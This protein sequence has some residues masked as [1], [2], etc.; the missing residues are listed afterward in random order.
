MN[1]I[2]LSCLIFACFFPFISPFGGN[3]DLDSLT[4]S[5]GMTPITLSGD[6]QQFGSSVV[7]CDFNGDGTKDIIFGAAGANGFAGAVYVL[8]GGASFTA[9]DLNPFTPSATKGLMITTSATYM[10]FGNI[11]ACVGDLNGDLREELVIGDGTGLYFYLVRPPATFIGNIELTSYADKSTFFSSTGNSEI[12]NVAALGDVNGDTRPDFILSIKNTAAGGEHFAVVYL[13]GYSNLNLDLDAPNPANAFKVTY[14]GQIGGLLS[15]A[16]AG[17]FND[18]TFADFAI[19][20][21]YTGD[22]AAVIFGGSGLGNIDLASGAFTLSKGVFIIGNAAFG[23]GKSIAYAGDVNGDKFSDIIIGASG[24]DSGNGAAFIIKGA[25]SFT[26]NIDVTTSPISGGS[27]GVIIKHSTVTGRGLGTSVFGGIKSDL[28]G[29][30]GTVIVCDALSSS[31]RCYFLFRALSGRAS[32]TDVDT[33]LTADGFAIRASTSSNQNALKFTNL[34]DINSDGSPDFMVAA[35]FAKPPQGA[36]YIVY[37]PNY[38]NDPCETCSSLDS[39]GWSTCLTCKIPS[40]Y[41]YF[42]ESSCYSTCPRG[43]FLPSGP[44]YECSSCDF[45]CRTCSTTADACTSCNQNGLYPYFYDSGC[46]STCPP[47]AP[48]VDSFNCVPGCPPDTVP[49]S[50]NICLVP[51]PEIPIVP[52]AVQVLSS[53]DQVKQASS[54]VMSIVSSLTSRGVHSMRSQSVQNLVSYLLFL[55]INYPS[56]YQ[57]FASKNFGSSRLPNPF[58]NTGETTRLLQGESLPVG[59]GRVESVNL[60]L[61]NQTLLANIGYSVLLLAICVLVIPLNDMLLALVVAQNKDC[62][63]KWYH[64]LLT[65]SSVSLRW[66]FL[67]NQFVSKYQDLVFFS[68]LG[69]YNSGGQD[70]LDTLNLVVC[71]IT[72]IIIVLGLIWLFVIIRNATKEFEKFTEEEKENEEFKKNDFLNRRI[73]LYKDLKK[74]HLM[75]MLYPFFLLVR[76][77]GFNFITIFLCHQTAIQLVYL[78]LTTIA[79][80]FYLLKYRP[81]EERIQYWITLAYEIAAYIAIFA[82]TILEIYNT[83]GGTS[84]NTQN[85]FGYFII[86]S[87]VA[88][89]ILNFIS[90]Y[91]EMQE[92]AILAYT[93]LRGYCEKRKNKKKIT[94]ITPQTPSKVEMFQSKDA[95]FT[96]PTA[97]F[98]K[99]DKNTPSPTQTTPLPVSDINSYFN[100]DESP[101]LPSPTNITR[102]KLDRDNASVNDKLGLIQHENSVDIRKN[103]VKKRLTKENLASRQSI[104]LPVD[105]VP[106]AEN[107]V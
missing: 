42:F 96:S 92:L 98:L 18:D 77:F 79:M 9:G 32:S 71:T 73:V 84:E 78:N 91:V 65:R 8:F 47:E 104:K 25:A 13:D 48:Y 16:S 70:D 106:E 107:L 94:P 29:K 52:E 74:D 76:I 34:G 103:S 99:K 10:G 19:G 30:D 100:K 105:Q 69:I 80:I 66:S 15:V 38:C 68:F 57:Q 90:F 43:T 60:Y 95:S 17:D 35:Q 21:L 31:G 88:I 23:L 46:Y 81:L 12:S 61:D 75:P 87:N 83:A 20:N 82:V 85:V 39:S 93:L 28:T 24:Y 86:V 1:Q 72:F 26:S 50:E 51:V 14:T 58:E 33:M 3:L 40:A 102:M 6:F 101:E 36:V 27:G 54:E 22:R 89:L 2:L 56:N 55:N 5:Q 49:D 64:K 62:E 63:S 11:L 59:N 41:P 67:L 7:H 97:S 53:V 44:G 37:G 45:N 4:S